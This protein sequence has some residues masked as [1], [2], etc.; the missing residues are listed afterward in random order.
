MTKQVATKNRR[1]QI[2][3]GETAQEPL[4]CPDY[5]TGEYRDLFESYAASMV[6]V[7]HDG[8]TE[9]VVELVR[10]RIMTDRS[11][12]AW[13]DKGGEFTNTSVKQSGGS[14]ENQVEIEV[15]DVAYKAYR[16]A[17]KLF[18]ASCRLLGLQVALGGSKGSSDVA[19]AEV[20]FK[21]VK[22]SV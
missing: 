13:Q 8:L 22:A 9:Q 21:A 11:W 5:V 15:E 20:A 16:E 19:V 2:T 6:G 17:H 18:L 4:V 7:W 12:Q 14:G 3:T 1:G 10:Q